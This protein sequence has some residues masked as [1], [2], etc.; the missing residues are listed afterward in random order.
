MSDEQVIQFVTKEHAAGTSQAQIVTKLMQK[1]VDISQIRRVRQRYERQINQKGLG[2]GADQAVSSAENRMRQANGEKKGNEQTRSTNM[3]RSSN[4]A[5]THT[6]TPDEAG[7]AAFQEE[8]G[9][10]LPT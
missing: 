3:V 9:M 6:F 5:Y 8:L 7:F 1:G 2:V 10:M 4:E